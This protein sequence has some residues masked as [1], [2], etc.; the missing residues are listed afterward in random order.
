MIGGSIGAGACANVN[1]SAKICK[2]SDDTTMLNFLSGEVEGA[3]DWLFIVIE[4]IVSVHIISA[5]DS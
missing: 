2:I 3:N 5:R 4:D 1:R